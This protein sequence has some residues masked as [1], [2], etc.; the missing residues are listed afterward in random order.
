[1]EGV[2]GAAVGQDAVQVR[3]LTTA[4]SSALSTG[5]LQQ[6]L[7]NR[8]IRG[9][10]F[11]LTSQAAQFVMTTASTVVLARLLTP[12]DFGLVAMVT[13]IVGLASAFADFGLSEATIQRKEISHDEVSTLFWVNV[14][15]G[16]GL[17]LITS[18]LGPVLAWVY[19]EPRLQNISFLFSLTFVIGGLR[20]QPNA[21]LRRQMRFSSLAMRDIVSQAVAVPTAIAMAWRGAGYWAL[22]A[23]P[24]VTNSTQM[25]LSWLMVHWRPGLPRRLG[26]LRSMLA[27]GGNV[28]ASYFIINMIRSMDAAL[29]GWYWGA[30]PLG[31]YSRAYNLLMLP[32]RQLSAPASSVAVPA[33]SRI[34]ADPER[35]ARYYLRIT[36]LIMWICAPLFGF[37]FAAAGPVIALVL[38]RQ[39]TEAAPVFQILVIS[40]FSQ[41][42]LEMSIWLLVSRGLSGRLLRLLFITSP[43]IIGAFAI[44]LPH[45]IRGVA[46]AGSIVQLAVL[47]WMAHFTFRG[48]NLNL[49]RLG[50]AILCPISLVFSGVLL[51]E[52]AKRV[53]APEHVVSQILVVVLGFAMAFSFLALIPA[54]REEVFSLRDLWDAFASPGRTVEPL[55]APL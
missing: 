34:H 26:S 3:V 21:L 2:V 42:F 14:A 7:K 23:L 51:T 29:I 40:G 47:P 32:V 17:A 13:A 1:L 15:I 44:G 43:I 36:N 28:S 49:R 5:H 30:G 6:D 52:V 9:G 22:V 18:G 35:L 10:V 27:F 53:I 37:L 11:T 39:W 48:T 41:L 50:R 4:E 55:S 31:I 45:G 24:L 8:S 25:A 46:L 33:F 12:A 20:V 54:V 16:L 19:R 38:G